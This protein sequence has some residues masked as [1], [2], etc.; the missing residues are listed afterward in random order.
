[1][2]FPA[3]NK[4]QGFEYLNIKYTIFSGVDFLDDFTFFILVRCLSKYL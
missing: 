1:M 3:F 2:N 4:V